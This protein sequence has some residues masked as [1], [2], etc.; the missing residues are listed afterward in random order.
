MPARQQ[1]HLA[2]GNHGIVLG[3]GDEGEIDRKGDDRD[4]DPEDGV[5]DVALDTFVLDNQ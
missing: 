5:R 3:R 4:A 1:R 2:V